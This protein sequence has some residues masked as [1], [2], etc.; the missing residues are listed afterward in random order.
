MKTSIS[1]IFIAV[2]PKIKFMFQ[3]YA[4]KILLAED[5]TEVWRKLVS[6]TRSVIQYNLY[7]PLTW[8]LP[9]VKQISLN[10]NTFC[11]ANPQRKYRIGL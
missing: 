1:L 3:Q 2:P 10:G 11:Y 7:F 4:G 8:P 5:K 6:G 9:V